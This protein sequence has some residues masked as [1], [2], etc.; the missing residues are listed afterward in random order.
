MGSYARYFLG[1]GGMQH[2]WNTVECW[3]YVQLRQGLSMLYILS[4]MT[5]TATGANHILLKYLTTGNREDGLKSYKAPV[6]MYQ[7][8]SN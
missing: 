5:L 1:D 7:G 8:C 2:C 3:V 4:A 6:C